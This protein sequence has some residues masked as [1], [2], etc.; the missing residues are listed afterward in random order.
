[1]SPGGLFAVRV[2]AVGTD[3]EHKHTV[4]ER[5]RDGSFSVRYL[6]GPKAGLTVH[7]WAAWELQ[8]LVIAAGF[9]PVLGL[10]PSAT[11]RK[12]NERGLWVQW[13]GIYVRVG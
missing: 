2:N 8:G 12:P 4:V 1:V 10:R 7:F 9:A 13:E 5:A 6:E 11:W 3:V